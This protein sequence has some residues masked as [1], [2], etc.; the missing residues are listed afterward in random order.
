MASNP[1]QLD[2]LGSK[3]SLDATPNRN[4]NMTMVGQQGGS[5]DLGP[6][7]LSN[8][9]DQVP[10]NKA[11][12]VHSHNHNHNHSKKQQQGIFYRFL[13]SELGRLAV[14]VVYF[15]VVC[16]F[17]AF[18]NQFS[19]HRW[20]ETGYRNILLE[21]RLF[22]IFPAQKDITPANIFVMTSVVFT[23]VGMALICP[24]W[25]AR[26]IVLRRVMW[27]VGTLSV[28]RSLTLSV[29]TLPTPK[30]GCKPATDKGFLEMFWIALQMIPGTVQAC[31]DDIFSGHTTF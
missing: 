21:D 10:E 24:T 3:E 5:A 4:S 11:P 17:M 22:D 20:V 7:P 25:T 23:L 6:S 18:C 19:D 29:T 14:S 16:I 1:E 30:E 9:I 31:T 26:G 28:Y 2:T 13:N 12:S 27:V 8:S 15:A